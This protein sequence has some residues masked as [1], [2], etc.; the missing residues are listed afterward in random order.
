[1]KKLLLVFLFIPL[2]SFGQ[3]TYAGYV[4]RN[5]SDQVDYSKIGKD[6]SNSLMDAAAKRESQA[7]ALGWSSAA[8]MDRARRANKLRIK[9]E[10][11]TRKRQRKL[12]KI[13]FKKAK[14]NLRRKIG[15]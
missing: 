6:L 8:E 12:D 2:V 3:K 5:A 13:R 11:K 14:K 7:R 1:M 9:A 4:P 10:K 15:N